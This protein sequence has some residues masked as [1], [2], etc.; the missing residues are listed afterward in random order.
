MISGRGVAGR[1]LAAALASSVCLADALADG[2]RAARERVIADV[3]YGAL[4]ALEPAD[5]EAES[6]GDD[7][8]A[9][10]I[11]SATQGLLLLFE[12]LNSEP[13]MRKLIALIHFDLGTHA[14]E[15]FDC[16]AIRKRPAIRSIIEE[17]LRNPTDPCTPEFGTGS[18]ICLSPE[19]TSSRLRSLLHMIDNKEE[20]APPR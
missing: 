9:D 7:R 11:A 1:I 12:D 14:S 10:R 15:T 6:K 17:E 5:R 18:P 19:Q 20:C 3:A 16:I 13:A 4:I 2:S 8:A